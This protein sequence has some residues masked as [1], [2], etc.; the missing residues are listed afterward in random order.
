MLDANAVIA[1]IRWLVKKRKSPNGRTA[2]QEA[3]ASKTLVAFAPS[4]LDD[5]IRL[6]LA[7][8][9]E[10]EGIPLEPMLEAWREYR[11]SIHFYEAERPATPVATPGAVDPHPP[12][13]PKD[14][15]YVETYLAVGAAAILTNDPHLTRMGARTVRFELAVAMRD[16]AR[17]ASIEL[18]LKWQGVMILTLAV[19]CINQLARL[20]AAVA[21]TIRR[22]PKPVQLALACGVLAALLHRPTRERIARALSTGWDSVMIAAREVL[23]LL[24]E[25][26]VVAHDE[27]ERAR[28]SWATL[29]PHVQPRRLPVRVH[30]FAVCAASERDLSTSEIMDELTRRGVRTSSPN[31]PRYL[32]SLLRQHPAVR[33]IQANRWAVVSAA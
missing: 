8:V 30:A 2:L 1:D 10:Y 20:V 5:E 18:T 17:A 19:G 13:D 26:V 28:A 33:E 22:S 11:A 12:V 4:F 16:Y 29:A 25:L 6:N 14:V 7:K 15:P 27:G 31:F 23:P 9:S 21:Q 32:R 3:I 24:G